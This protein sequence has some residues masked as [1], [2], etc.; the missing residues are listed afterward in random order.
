MWCLIAFKVN[1]SKCERN[2]GSGQKLPCT[3][4]AEIHFGHYT[5]TLWQTR[6]QHRHD[7]GQSLPL[8][9]SQTVTALRHGRF[10]LSR[11]RLRVM[12]G[13]RTRKQQQSVVFYICIFLYLYIFFLMYTLL[14]TLCFISCTRCTFQPLQN[15]QTKQI[16]KKRFQCSKLTGTQNSQAWHILACPFHFLQYL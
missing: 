5:A 11:S 13:D 2:G 7:Q 12:A 6:T 9:F 14:P 3:Q 1:G 15:C 4:L 10:H 16:S 8:L